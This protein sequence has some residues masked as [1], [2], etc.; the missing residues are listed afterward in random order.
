MKR[1]VFF[2]SDGTGITA[3]SFG[4]S[5]LAQFEGL[6]ARHT[7]LPYVNNRDK[8]LEA[9]ALI[10]SAKE[11][12]S[13]L[14]LLFMTVVN[15][16]VCAVLQGCGAYTVDLFAAFM[17]NLEKELGQH[18]LYR[19]GQK[20]STACSS[21]TYHR[22]IEAVQFALENDDGV[23]NRHYDKADIILLGASRSGK[24]PTCIYLGL[25][26]GI[27]AA[28][29]PIAEEDLEE[30]NRLP[31]SLL[32]YQSR[33]FGLTIDPDRL[34]G[35]RHER[36]PNS[37]YASG[38]QCQYEVRAIEYLY[39]RSGIKYINTTDYSVEEIATRIMALA[40]L[41]RRLK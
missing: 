1:S 14:P 7:T 6:E 16:D 19:I 22:R 8:A 31:T 4:Q 38:R 24:T 2:V 11:K 20:R 36:K 25:Q 32:P 3:E 28:N 23:H 21:E 41:E 17:P 5:L 35:I 34:A 26:F 37:R 39:E 30:G 10:Q 18:A 33:L 13:Q 9:L 27:F 15:K 40:N 29:Y 12:D